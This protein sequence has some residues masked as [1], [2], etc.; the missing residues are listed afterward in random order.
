MEILHQ[1]ASKESESDEEIDFNN[2]DVVYE[3]LTVDEDLFWYAYIKF[4]G[5][6]IKHIFFL[7]CSVL[8]NTTKCNQNIKRTYIQH[9]FRI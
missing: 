6:L 3:D 8:L 5:F 1:G 2:L 7:Y 4:F 9:F